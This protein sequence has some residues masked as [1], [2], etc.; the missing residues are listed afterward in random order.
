MKPGEKA[1]FGPLADLLEGVIPFE[2]GKIRES[3][4]DDARISYR[5]LPAPKLPPFMAEELFWGLME[6]AGIQYRLLLQIAQLSKQ[7]QAARKAHYEADSHNKVSRLLAAREVEAEL[8]RQLARLKEAP[9]SAE[10]VQERLFERA[11]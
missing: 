4:T 9:K 10:P 6:Q 1:P 2:G 7:Y 11:P 3:W 5:N 8:A